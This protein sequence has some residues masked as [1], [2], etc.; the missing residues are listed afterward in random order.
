MGIEFGREIG[1][2]IAKFCLNKWK[3]FLKKFL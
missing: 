3:E 1:C 2:K